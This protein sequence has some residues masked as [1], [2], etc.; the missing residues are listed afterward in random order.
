MANLKSEFLMGVVVGAFL[1]LVMVNATQLNVADASPSP[2]LQF[3]V[4]GRQYLPKGQNFRVG[5]VAGALDAFLLVGHL[6]DTGEQVYDFK[7]CAGNWTNHELIVLVDRY[8]GDNPNERNLSAA[9]LTHDALKSAC[10]N[11]NTTGQ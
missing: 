6:A 5:Y 9:L 8:M 3:K 1:S 4:S 11:L 2:M 10:Q 7:N